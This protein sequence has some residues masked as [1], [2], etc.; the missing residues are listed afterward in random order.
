MATLPQEN[1]LLTYFSQSSNHPNE[2]EKGEADHDGRGHPG[3]GVEDGAI[4]IS[5][6]QLLIIDKQEHEDENKGQDHS[7]DHLGEIHDRDEREVG[8]ENDPCS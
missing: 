1:S 3:N 2:K 4:G 5:H 8:I 6:H 7:I